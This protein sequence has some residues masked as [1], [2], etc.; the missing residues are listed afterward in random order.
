MPPDF[1]IQCTACGHEAVWDTDA[2][3][4]VGVPEVGHPVLW[5][6]RTCDREMRHTIVDLYVIMD[7]LHH[8]ICLATELDR[9]MVDRVMD[10]AYRYRQK[11]SE[12]SPTAL[13]GPAQEVEEV[14]EAARVPLEVVE[15][16]SVA[17][18]DWMLRRGYIV[19]DPAKD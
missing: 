15:Q 18:A 3:P 4:P 2:V 1:L 16:I 5:R 11:A 7:K 8:E 13:P 19:D 12:E 14:A 17:E 9:A 10:A 6:C